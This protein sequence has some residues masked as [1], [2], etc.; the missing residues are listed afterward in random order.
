MTRAGSIWV[1][2]G[3]EAG[4][5]KSGMRM[6]RTYTDAL[7]VLSWM[8]RGAEGGPKLEW[9]WPAVR[10]RARLPAS[11]LGSLLLTRRVLRAGGA[12]DGDLRAGKL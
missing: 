3:V 5:K 7:A 2:G 9:T 1:F 4:A 8:P 10:R 11:Q 6:E 12:A